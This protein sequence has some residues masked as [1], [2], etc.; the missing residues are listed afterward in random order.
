[1]YESLNF[2]ATIIIS[3]MTLV[4]TFFIG[5]P[6]IKK[7]LKY[8]EFREARKKIT[9]RSVIKGMVSVAAISGFWTLLRFSSFLN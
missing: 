3:L 5:Y 6:Q 2:A 1:M 4:V 9:R 7:T 8:K